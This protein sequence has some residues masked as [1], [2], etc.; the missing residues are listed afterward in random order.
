MP[1]QNQPQDAEAASRPEHFSI[2][3]L[4]LP[5][6]GD[7]ISEDFRTVRL[8]LASPSA[9]RRTT[10]ASSRP[11]RAEKTGRP[12]NRTTGARNGVT[13]ICGRRCGSSRLHRFDS[14]AADRMVGGTRGAIVSEYSDSSGT[15]TQNGGL[16]PTRCSC[17]AF[18]PRPQ[19]WRELAF[20]AGQGGMRTTEWSQRARTS[21]GHGPLT[22]GPPGRGR[23]RI[24]SAKVGGAVAGGRHR[25]PQSSG[26]PRVWKI[27]RGR[28]R[29][30][31]RCWRPSTLQSR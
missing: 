8:L 3:I 12:R 15:Y 28:C 7:A 24:H 10:S 26:I 23:L 22:M 21:R 1:L 30:S 16:A 20:S 6:R 5:K 25:R 19:I 9:S 18:L 17:G 13:T 14:A 4:M 29:S 2:R 27:P 31:D 11:F